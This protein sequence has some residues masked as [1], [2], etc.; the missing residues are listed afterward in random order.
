MLT[1]E[2]LNKFRT[3]LEDEKNKLERELEKVGKRNPEVKGDWVVEVPDLN[4]G[5]S[6]ENDISDIYEELENRNALGDNLEENLTLVNKALERV[7]GKTYGL[8]EVCR[9]PIDEKRLEAYPAA[10]TCVKHAKS[11]SVD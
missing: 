3:I 7:K 1:A 6:D 8:C 5:L 9:Q 11:V 2:Q 10:T 4:V